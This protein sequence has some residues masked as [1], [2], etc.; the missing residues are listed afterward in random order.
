MASTSASTT[1]PAGNRPGARTMSGHVHQ[2]LVHAL[3]VPDV[4]VLPELVAV[5]GDDDDGGGVVEAPRA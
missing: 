3:G 5:I 1:L 4:A 2:L